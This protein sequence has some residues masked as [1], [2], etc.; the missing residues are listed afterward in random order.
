MRKLKAFLLFIA[1]AM[2]MWSGTPG[3]EKMTF[4][5]CSV[6]HAQDDWK[7]EFDDVCAKTQDAMMFSPDELRSLVAR[8]DKLKSIIEKLDETQR[9]VYLRRLQ[10]CRD[11]F[12]FVLESKEKQ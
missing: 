5:W 10:L 6:V 3:T 2:I 9:K 12:S 7:H 1:A 11:L 4:P 8:C